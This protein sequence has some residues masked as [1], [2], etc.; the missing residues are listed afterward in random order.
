MTAAML[1]PLLFHWARW[2]AALATHYGGLD[3]LYRSACGAGLVVLMLHRLNDAR[4]PYPLS[5]SRATLRAMAGLLR[6]RRALVSLDEGLARLDAPGSRDTLYA[7]TFDDG[8][9]DNLGVLEG[10]A[11]DAPIPALVYV[12][13][14]HVGAEPIWPY[15]LQ[16]AVEAR[17]CDVVDA[18]LPGVAPFDLSRAEERDRLYRELPPLLKRQPPEAIERLVDTVVAQARPQPPEA[19]ATMLDWD[20]VRHLHARGVGIGAHTR[21]HAILARVDDAS[22]ASEI[23]GSRDDL[24]QA[25]GEPP[26]HFAYPNGGVADFGERDVRLVREA[27]FATAVTTVEGVNRRGVDRHRLHRHNVHERRFIAPTGH[28]SR[29]LLLSETSGLLGWLRARRAS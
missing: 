20:D 9:R 29:A 25:L 17:T 18:A 8:Y 7:I 13:T 6:R 11:Q 1:Q 21:R 24:E 15:R 26:R 27:G 22:A 14:G 23:A 12:T 2:L 5:T 16:H 3:A 19:S 4:D 28:L 10:D